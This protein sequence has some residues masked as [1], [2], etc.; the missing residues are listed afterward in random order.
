MRVNLN[1][2]IRLFEFVK[3]CK[4]RQY[5]NRLKKIIINSSSFLST[6]IT[7]KSLTSFFI[8]CVKFADKSDCQPRINERDCFCL[9][10]HWIYT[11]HQSFT[12]ILKRRK[13]Q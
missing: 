13:D 11:E 9:K 2:V 1:S 10:S 7:V 4:C 3:C 12:H 6:S 5:I 8:Y